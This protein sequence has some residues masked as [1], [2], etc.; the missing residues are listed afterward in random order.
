MK[1]AKKIA[2]VAHDNQKK[3]LIE[4]IDWNWEILVDHELI[5]TGTTGTLVEELLSKKNPGLQ[6]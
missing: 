2:L 4:W 1:K 3:T 5:C 6:A